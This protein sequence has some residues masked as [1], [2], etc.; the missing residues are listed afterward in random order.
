MKRGQNMNFMSV[1][2]Q[3]LVLFL[4]IIIGFAASKR[5]WINSEGS[6]QLSTIVLYI[7]LPALIIRS[8]QF[9][10]SLELLA[11]SG[12]MVGI[13]AVTYTSIIML[14]YLFIRLTGSTG[15]QKDVL[16]V[17]M[18]FPNGGFMGYPIILAV[19]GAQGVF[20]TALFNMLFD[21]LIWTVGL[22]MLTR[23][24]D[25]TDESA[26]GFRALLNPGTIAVFIGFMLF[27]FSLKLPPSIDKTFEYLAG[28]T[29]PLAMITVGSILAKTKI[30]AIFTNKKLL[31]TAAVKM[32]LVPGILLTA[33]SLTP[34]TGYFK[35][36]PVIIMS[37]PVAAN[38]AILSTKYQ[39]DYALASEAVFLTTMISMLTIPLVVMLVS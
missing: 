6:K 24:S 30:S 23:S 25:I 37:M 29:T 19:Y 10:F 14:S 22:H 35:T 3:V 20:Y 31:I 13:S 4:L 16:Q 36:I 38:V 34:L 21:I 32:I 26:K 1:F 11:Q 15:K 27:A 17:A 12:A 39:S 5:N 28:A 9:D 2:T 33:F 8:M 18:I 7:T